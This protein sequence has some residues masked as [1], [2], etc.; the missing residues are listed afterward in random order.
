M[1]LYQ[2]NLRTGQSRDHLLTIELVGYMLS[3]IHVIGHSSVRLVYLSKSSCGD[4]NR[5]LHFMFA[6]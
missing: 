5:G 6:L 2:R 3:Y 4:Y 1:R